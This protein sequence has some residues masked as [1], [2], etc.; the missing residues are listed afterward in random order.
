MG[1]GVREFGPGK[2]AF[3]CDNNFL[4]NLNVREGNDS[5]THLQ[6]LQVV[7]FKVMNK[8]ICMDRRGG[9][10]MVSQSTLQ[11]HDKHT[12]RHLFRRKKNS[13]AT[14]FLL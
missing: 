13:T 10:V 5:L 6:S 4:Q 9:W 3:F 12:L 8:S 7:I 11:A 2:R 14:S 1:L